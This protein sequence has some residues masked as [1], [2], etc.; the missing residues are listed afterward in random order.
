VVVAA[1]AAAAGDQDVV[2][3]SSSWS[4]AVWSGDWPLVVV[5]HDEQNS[6]K[7]N[8]LELQLLEDIM[9]VR[10]GGGGLKEKMKKIGFHIVWREG[11]ERAQSLWEGLL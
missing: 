11:A 3:N 5:L 10:A 2:C 9:R 7:V 1:G 8:E 4:A 6:G